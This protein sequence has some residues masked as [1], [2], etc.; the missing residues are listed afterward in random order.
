MFDIDG[1]ASFV[2]CIC[3]SVY[4]LYT[5]KHC[6]KVVQSLVK[7]A[8]VGGWVCVH[9]PLCTR[10]GAK[11]CSNHY[12]FTSRSFHALSA[13]FLI[14]SN[15]PSFHIPTLLYAHVFLWCCCGAVNIL[16][17]YIVKNSLWI[18]CNKCKCKSSELLSL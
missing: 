1:S 16:Q 12:H 2:R 15:H 13:Y 7:G 17:S 6:S 8:C 4:T 3:D 9:A 10:M 18:T 14:F 5:C 11:G